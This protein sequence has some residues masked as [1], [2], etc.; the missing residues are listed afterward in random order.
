MSQHR[1]NN[2][3]ISTQRS[4]DETKRTMSRH[5]VSNVAT[6]AEMDNIANPM[7]RHQH[8]IKI[9]SQRANVATPDST[10]NIEVSMSKH[11]HDNSDKARFFLVFSN[12]V[13]VA[14]FLRPKT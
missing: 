2:V 8:D 5:Q 1:I 14:S 13:I 12:A 3:V 6:L 4:Q 10:H 9:Q 11:R 7:S